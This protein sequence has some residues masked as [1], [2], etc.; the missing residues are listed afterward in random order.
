MIA[1]KSQGIETCVVGG[2]KNYSVAIY[3]TRVKHGKKD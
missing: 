2:G 3:S 1:A